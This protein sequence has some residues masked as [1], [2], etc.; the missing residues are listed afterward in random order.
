LIANFF[1]TKTKDKKQNKHFALRLVTAF[2]ARVEHSE[3]IAIRWVAVKV[4]KLVRLQ[5]RRAR[6]HHSRPKVTTTLN[7]PLLPDRS[8]STLKTVLFLHNF[9][10]QAFS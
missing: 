9:V 10:F 4:P 5:V 1:K 2:Y 7:L 8:V 6:R 3:K